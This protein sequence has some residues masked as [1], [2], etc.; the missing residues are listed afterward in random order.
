MTLHPDLSGRRVPTTFNVYL[1]LLFTTQV[2]RQ[3]VASSFHTRH[4][5]E[6]TKVTTTYRP[7]GA[8]EYRISGFYTPIAPLG[9]CKSGKSLWIPIYR[10]CPSIVLKRVSKVKYG[11]TTHTYLTCNLC[12]GLSLVHP[13]SSS[14]A[15][16]GVRCF[17]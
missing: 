9:L 4:L 7:A 10:G 12:T 2:A 11:R 6:L 3:S 5:L 17:C 16:A 15:W 13:R 14:T 8:L 1:F